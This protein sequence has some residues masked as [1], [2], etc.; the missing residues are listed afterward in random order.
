MCE[1]VPFYIHMD[2]QSLKKYLK[3]S[4]DDFIEFKNFENQD[5]IVRGI[6]DAR[7][8][9][10]NTICFVDKLQNDFQKIALK[11][12]VV[13]TNRELSTELGV[14][15]MIVVNDPREFFIKYANLLIS[16]REL[17]SFISTVVQ[18]SGID[19]TAFIHP[20]TT[21]EEGVFIGRGSIISS[22]VV[23]KK[24]TWIG[25]DVVVRENTVIGCDG[26]ALYKTLDNRVLRFPHM[27]G[28]IVHNGVEIG[29]GCVIPRG[30][31]T[32]TIIGEHT[33]IGNLSNIGHACRLGKKVWMS[34]GCLIGG[35]T[36]IGDYCTFGLGATVRDNLTIENNCS[37]GM[38]GV[39]TNNLQEN[40][41]VFGNPAKR[42]PQIK[43][44]PDR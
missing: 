3:K 11:D 7:Y 33:V 44:G 35:N 18:K 41:S 8:V 31:L 4:F 10:S 5:W 2:I 43:A 20:N 13:I 22:G 12:A 9:A 17:S 24:G 14:M 40:I 28:V 37:V 38:G 36:R 16:R 27:A 32:P 29:A 6:S 15:P 19:T 30:V 26:I 25:E 34:V 42:V 39:V 23:I 21:I 1:Y